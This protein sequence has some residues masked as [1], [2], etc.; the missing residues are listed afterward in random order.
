MS[1]NEWDQVD[2]VE[3]STQ[4]LDAKVALMSKQWEE[5]EEAKKLATE[6]RERYDKTEKEILGMLKAAKKTKY[7]VDGLGTVSVRNRYVVRVPKGLT[8][9]EALFNYIKEKQ[10]YESFMGMVSVNHMTLNSWVNAEKEAN[11]LVE[12]P[13]IEAPTHE[14]SLAFRQSK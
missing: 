2:S 9:K 3:I 8:E 11:P 4:E 12:I 14:E 7:H 5:Y 10:G 1:L 13:G 6:S